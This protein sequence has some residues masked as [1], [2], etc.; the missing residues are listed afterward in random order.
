MRLVQVFKGKVACDCFGSGLIANLWLW[1][2]INRVCIVFLVSC[3][4]VMFENRL[5][6]F[7]IEF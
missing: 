2:K 7:D 3:A 5:E 6:I 4:G 1:L